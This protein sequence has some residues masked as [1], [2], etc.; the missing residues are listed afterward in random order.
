MELLGFLT[1]GLSFYWSKYTALG[2][3]GRRGIESPFYGKS[4]RDSGTATSPQVNI[5]LCVLSG[6]W[7]VGP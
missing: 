6:K 7:R 4:E 2:D 1:T 3:S 5:Q